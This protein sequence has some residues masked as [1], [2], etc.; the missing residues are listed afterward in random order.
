[1]GE[2]FQSDNP[3]TYHDPR[4]EERWQAYAA[5]AVSSPETDAEQAATRADLLLW[6]HRKRFPLPPREGPYR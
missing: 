6:D 4:D 5:A 1:M 2:P 3:R